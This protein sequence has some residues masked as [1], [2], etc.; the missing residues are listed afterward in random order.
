MDNAMTRT[1]MFNDLMASIKNGVVALASVFGIGVT[2]VGVYNGVSADE[3]SVEEIKVPGTFEEQ[4]YKSDT[5]TLRILDE[6]KKYQDS[7]GS[8]KERVNFFGA[9]NQQMQTSNLQLAGTG[10]DVKAI[11]SFIRDSLGLV[12]AKVSG[13]ITS[14]KEADVTEYHIKIRRC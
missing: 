13:E 10:I 11:Q 3:I 4:G 5:T 2:G 6:I 14:R 7:N 9:S 1:Q 8:A 12:T